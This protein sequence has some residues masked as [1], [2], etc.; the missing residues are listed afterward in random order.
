MRI[1]SIYFISVFLIVFLTYPT[2]PVFYEFFLFDPQLSYVI[3]SLIFFSI[4]LFLK[5]FNLS[6]VKEKYKFIFNGYIITTLYLIFSFFITGNY[7]AIREIITF[8]S[9]I[10]F[11]SWSK[12]DVTTLVY[13][14]IF[15]VSLIAFFSNVSNLLFIIDPTIIEAWNVTE[16]PL[17]E[18]NPILSRQYY[19]D[20]EYH[21]LFYSVNI[22]IIFND[23]FLVRL[24]GIFT[25]PSFAG[26]Y[27][28]PVLLLIMFLYKELKVIGLLLICNMILALLLAN[29]SIVNVLVI[30]VPA[31]AVF[32][33]NQGINNSNLL[34]TVF[35]VIIILILLYPQLLLNFL[36]FLPDIKADQ[37]YI[38]LFRGDFDIANTV[39][40]FGI[41]GADL[42]FFKSS[43]I[44][45]LGRYG[46]IGY[47]IYVLW[48]FYLIYISFRVINN[49]SIEKY[50]RILAFSCIFISSILILR[51]TIYIPIYTIFLVIF[52]NKTFNFPKTI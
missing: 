28:M 18:T 12:K 52:F 11:L 3:F 22:P 30:L 42:P 51:S 23:D 36:V 24:P 29:S 9:I 49:K 46:I 40:L 10:A 20:A 26:Y 13:F 14:L 8:T 50:K 32:Y 17:T 48:I 35:V 2:A 27:F 21:L 4:I 44:A 25:E 6:Y 43:I 34:M 5:S 19:G 7:S 16:L 31:L 47:F 1:I 39:S 45:I 15:N 33:V 41:N 37:L 38:M